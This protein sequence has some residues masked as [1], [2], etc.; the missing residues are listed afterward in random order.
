MNGLC[1]QFFSC[2][3]LPLY[4][5]CLIRFSKHFQLFDA[6]FH[7]HGPVYNII[8]RMLRQKPAFLRAHRSALFQATQISYI[9]EKIE[10]LMDVCAEFNNGMI[11]HN[12]PPSD[13]QGDR[14]ILH[15]LKLLCYGLGKH[16]LQRKWRILHRTVGEL[17]QF[18]IRQHDL[19]T[20]KRKQK[21]L[22]HVLQNAFHTNVAD[23]SILIPLGRITGRNH[24]AHIMQERI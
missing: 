20:R 18:G 7:R 17:L 14:V 22:F 21:A 9:R 1:Q 2:T 5:D 4:Q 10:P 16:V 13:I 3:T 19:T 11:H 23:Q 6:L 8:K 15:F 12:L 24:Q